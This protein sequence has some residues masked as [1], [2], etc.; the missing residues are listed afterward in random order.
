MQNNLFLPS[1]GPFKK[2]ERLTHCTHCTSLEATPFAL[3][4]GKVWT[5]SG[6]KVEYAHLI[7]MFCRDDQ[8]GRLP[9]CAT[10]YPVL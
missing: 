2:N 3:F 6:N 10:R 4:G 9:G 1:N 7:F 8:P 5:N